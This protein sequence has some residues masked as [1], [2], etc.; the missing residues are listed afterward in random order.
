MCQTFRSTLGFPLALVHA[1]CFFSE[2]IIT[3][4]RYLD[5]SDANDTSGI[6]LLSEDFEDDAGNPELTSPI[7][8]TWVATLDYIQEHRPLAANVFHMTGIFDAH[9]IRPESFVRLVDD[10]ATAPLRMQQ[11]LQKKRFQTCL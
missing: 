2:N 4:A 7:A 6:H 9:A 5:L 11:V 10:G 1:T 3:I 8:G